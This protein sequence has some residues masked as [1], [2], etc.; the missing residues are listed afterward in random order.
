VLRKYASSDL[1]AVQE[2]VVAAVMFTAEEAGFLEGELVPGAIG[3]SGASGEAAGDGPVSEVATVDGVVVG[4]VHYRPEEAAEAVWD[5][6]MIAVAPAHQ[7]TGIGRDL[8]RHVEEA[9]VARGARLLVVRTSGTDQYAQ[10]RA[11]YGRTGYTRSA[12]VPDWWADG[13][14]LI[15]HVK[16]LT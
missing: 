13:D 5:L 3:P 4:V 10:A 14:D 12:V 2:L 8:L 9:L 16:R 6:T 15:L 11:F 1:A 7:G